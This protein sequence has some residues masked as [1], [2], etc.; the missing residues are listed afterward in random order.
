MS[1]PA[2]GADA[3]AESAGRGRRALVVAVV[4]ALAVIFVFAGK[5]RIAPMLS[6]TLEHR[7]ALGGRNPQACLGCHRPDGPSRP[8]PSGH[9]PRQDCWDCHVVRPPS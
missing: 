5:G 4:V 9:T 7:A 8:R 6:P 1:T 3:S 2:G